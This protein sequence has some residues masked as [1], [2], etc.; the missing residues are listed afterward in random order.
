LMITSIAWLML[1]TIVEDIPKRDGSTE[2]SH[3][4][5]RSWAKLA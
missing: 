2:A 1:P 3:N 5:R 4:S